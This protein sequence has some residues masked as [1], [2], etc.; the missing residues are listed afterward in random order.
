MLTWQNSAV[1]F[2][3]TLLVAACATTP[4]FNDLEAVNKSVQPAMVVNAVDKYKGERVLWGGIIINSINLKTGTQ[5]E[6]LA[7]PLNSHYKP[8]AEQR[9]SGRFLI[10]YNG[11][12]ETVDYAPG[13]LLTVVGTV[14]GLKQGKV[15][16]AEYT[17]P[18][19]Q[20]DQLYLWPLESSENQN[21]TFHFGVG[22]GM[23][24][25]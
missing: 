22:V 8:K 23:V 20:A 16:E 7:Q 18:V 25:H 24:F 3:M 19:I 13:R 2:A 6:I 4:K 17:Y 10:F 11:Y 9:N 1:L 14:T 15:G 12:L 5:L 21:G